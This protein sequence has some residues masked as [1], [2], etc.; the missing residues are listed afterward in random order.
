[1]SQAVIASRRKIA[2]MSIATPT[3]ALPANL[4]TVLETDSL[5]VSMS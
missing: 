5:A 1:M 4:D 3:P 2:A